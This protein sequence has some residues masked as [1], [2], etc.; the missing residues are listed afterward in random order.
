MSETAG[1]VASG[2]ERAAAHKVNKSLWTHCAQPCLTDPYYSVT[3][4]H[5]HRIE[6]AAPAV[7]HLL[8]LLY[9]ISF[10]LYYTTRQSRGS[11]N[12]TAKWSQSFTDDTNIWGKAT[13]ITGYFIIIY[14]HK[15]RNS[16]KTSEVVFI[17]H[18]IRM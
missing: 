12:A 9:S 1:I 7:P 16:D 4:N 5:I 13:A 10:L 3:S 18:S 17:V 14:S 15:M 2:S 11:F 6:P 8:H